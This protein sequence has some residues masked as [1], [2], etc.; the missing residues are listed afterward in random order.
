[1]NTNNFCA[2]FQNDDS[3]NTTFSYQRLFH[4]RHLFPYTLGLHAAED[5]GRTEE[6]TEHKK[7][8][9]RQEEGRVFFTAD[10][11][12][13]AVIIVPA[14]ILF[15]AGLYFLETLKGYFIIYLL[16][17]SGNP[18]NGENLGHVL[19]DVL[20]IFI[21]VF[22]PVG[23]AA[24]LTAVI[25]TMAQTGWHISSKNLRFDP[26]RIM[27]SW[28]N[29][30]RKTILNR[31]QGFNTVK[32]II[33]MIIIG[34][35]TVLFIRAFL[36]DM[37]SLINAEVP[38]A[39]SKV[40]M[41]VFKM[42][43]II[44][45]LLLIIALPDWF[46]QRSEYIEQLKMTKEEV[47]QEF[48]ETEGDPQVRN[49]QRE[50]AREILR[51]TMMQ[52][53]KTADVVITNPTHFACAVQYQSS[54]M[55]APKLVA[56]GMDAMAQKIRELAKENEIPL[57]ENKELARALYRNV[58]VGDFIPEQFWAPVAEILSMLAKFKTNAA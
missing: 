24:V 21:K 7:T 35:A 47:K 9:A 30:K 5:E 51:K 2:V 31:T 8:K 29:L 37:I 6:P 56:K 43:I 20:I 42:I 32:L 15:L 23:A 18:I 34:A 49:R 46:V 50:R 36:P 14:I 13:S 1:M 3:E 19:R 57:V 53:V 55:H 17:P 48:K 12:Q 25:T 22:A 10:F 16:N 44:S 58:E 27:P 41:I 40:S 54:V 45:V 28:E 11:P 39:F 33:K 52:N 38:L 4:V 26:N